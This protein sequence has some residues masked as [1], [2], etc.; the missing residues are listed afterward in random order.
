MSTSVL[1]GGVADVVMPERL[2]AVLNEQGK[3]RVIELNVDDE[4]LTELALM[5][6]SDT[7]V[8]V[9]RGVRLQTKIENVATIVLN[10]DKFE[11]RL[12]LKESNG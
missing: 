11:H 1:F 6:R 12:P 10:Q 9:F 5:L 3:T 8:A 7:L 4:G 2:F